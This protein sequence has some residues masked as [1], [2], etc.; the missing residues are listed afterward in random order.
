MTG[1]ARFSKLYSPA[2]KNCVRPL[3]PMGP[4]TDKAVCSSVSFVKSFP[5]AALFELKPA[6]AASVAEGRHSSSNWP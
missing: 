2:R 4:E 1:E 6:R 5:L 3:L